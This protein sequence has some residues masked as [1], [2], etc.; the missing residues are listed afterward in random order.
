VGSG[1]HPSAPH[2]PPSLS[3]RRPGDDSPLAL[4]RT[5][6]ELQEALYRGLPASLTQP[7]VVRS[8]VGSTVS[9]K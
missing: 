3:A 8:K 1:G 6:K 5:R 7:V 4:P 9:T 2:R